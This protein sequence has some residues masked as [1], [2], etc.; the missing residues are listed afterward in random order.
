MTDS[1]Y[2]D[3]M[4]M[5]VACSTA[6]GEGASSFRIRT[7]QACLVPSHSATSNMVRD[8]DIQH[9]WGNVGPGIHG[10]EA[11]ELQRPVCTVYQKPAC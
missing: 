8:L 4:E 9:V 10:V 1:L 5:P 2:F 3:I 11:D 7:R 6:R